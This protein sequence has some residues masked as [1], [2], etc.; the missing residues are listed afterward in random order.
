MAAG[1]EVAARLATEAG[2]GGEAG[3]GGRIQALDFATDLAPTASPGRLGAVAA[4]SG[5]RDG[6]GELGDG[7]GVAALA[8]TAV[9]DNCCWRRWLV[10]AASATAADLQRP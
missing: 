8:V 9:C 7:V 10:I 1:M 3:I 6:S 2:S 4:A 5:G